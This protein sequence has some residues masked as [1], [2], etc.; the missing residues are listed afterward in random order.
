MELKSKI[1]W[2]GL[3]AGPALASISYFLMPESYLDVNGNSIEFASAG[4]VTLSVLVLMA[5]WWLTEA[6][7]ISATALLPVVLF[8]L[9]GATTVE[10]ATAPYSHPLVF[11]VLG[12]F[13][14][15]IA[16]E[17]WRLDRRI[18]YNTLRLVG[19]DP[20]NMIGGVMLVTAFLSAF[21]SNTATAAMMLP[22]AMSVIELASKS[23][24]EESNFNVAMLLGIAYAASIGGIAT[25]IGTGPNAFL[26]GFISEEYHR[27]LSFTGWLPIGLS[28]TLLF[29]P[30]TWIILT[31]ILYPVANDPIEGGAEM[32]ETGLKE[33]GP[34]SKA[35]KLTLMV[36]LIAAFLWTFRPLLAGLL[37]FK[38]LTD[39]GISMFCALLLFIIPVNLKE[40]R[41]LLDWEAAAKIPWGILL[42]FGGGLSLSS[43][44]QNTGVAEFI[45][46]HAGLLTALPAFM[47]ILLVTFTVTALTE[48]TSNVATTASFLPI[49]A[50]LAPA[51]KIDP[52]SLI[53]AATLASSC[54]FM[55]PVATPPNA[56]VFGSGKLKMAQMI[57][58]GIWLN[59]V[60]VI[61]VSMIALVLVPI[62]F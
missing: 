57:R 42:L 20:I 43:A 33:L 23:E 22:I 24:K 56:I 8:P 54:A 50:S 32:I 27:E 4:R 34:V 31:K 48:L 58:A 55:M 51:L 62:F 39:A 46:S 47:H 25:I 36:F 17:K 52:Y 61:L 35:E 53:V 9:L 10:A 3:I 59:L 30:L 18:A 6:I 13:L 38:G 49:L 2:L 41:F 37:A 15:A 28:V 44:V 16:L 1:Q 7:H 60:G 21:V 19:C 26:V 5:V 40:R 45:G 14:I 29:L 12:G 11:L